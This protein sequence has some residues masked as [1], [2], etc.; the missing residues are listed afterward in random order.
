MLSGFVN[1]DLQSL[2]G[3]SS[4]FGLPVVYRMDGRILVFLAGGDKN[5]KEVHY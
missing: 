4:E 3:F 2:C 5:K 1:S